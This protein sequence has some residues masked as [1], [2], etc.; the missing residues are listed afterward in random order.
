M[1]HYPP[2]SE[3]AVLFRVLVLHDDHLTARRGKLVGL[4]MAEDMGFSK[5]CSLSLWNVGLLDTSFGT[6]AAEDAS[7]SD[8]VVVALRTCAGLSLELRM[9]LCRWLLQSKDSAAAL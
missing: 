5:E 4:S 3:D 7:I 9:W 2:S 6:K 1:P 8:V